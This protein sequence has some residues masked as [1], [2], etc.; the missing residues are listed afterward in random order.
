M[1]KRTSI[2]RIL[3]AGIASLAL[4][5][6][7]VGC[8]EGEL[9]SA[10][11]ISE[12]PVQTLNF[13][14]EWLI[15]GHRTGHVCSMLIHDGHIKHTQL[16]LWVLTDS[17]N[18]ALTAQGQEAGYSLRSLP[19]FEPA[20]TTLG[21]YQGDYSNSDFFTIEPLA[22][23]FLVFRTGQTYLPDVKATIRMTPQSNASV[24]TITRGSMQMTADILVSELLLD[25][26]TVRSYAQPMHLTFVSTELLDQS[27]P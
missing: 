25:D 24:L 10:A 20:I 1:M 2:Q 7:P 26:Q 8:T 23:D 15:D 13:Q 18:A 3:S 9:D 17:I 4:T 6:M 5:V 12:M 19:P 22:Y 16:P 11:P 14:G 21:Y 27:E